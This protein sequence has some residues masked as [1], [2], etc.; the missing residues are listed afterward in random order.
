MRGESQ[1]STTMNG[2]SRGPH[3][4]DRESGNTL[5]YPYDLPGS[6]SNPQKVPIQV[7]NLFHFIT[8]LETIE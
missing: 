1:A 7:I 2:E 8:S 3:V 5:K 4:I 6:V